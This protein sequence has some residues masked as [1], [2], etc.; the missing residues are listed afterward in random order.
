[1]RIDKIRIKNFRSFSDVEVKVAPYTSLVGP[2]GSGKSTILCA[3]NVF[4]RE[5]ENVATN[6]SDLDAEDFHNRNTEEPIEITVTFNELSDV[7]QKELKDYYRQDELVLGAE[8]QF[9]PVTQRAT[10]RQFGLRS[11]MAEFKEFF[12]LENDKKKVDELKAAYERIR[13]AF[14]ELPKPGSKDSMHDALRQYEEAHPELCVLIASPDQLYGIRGVGRL[15]PFIQWVY[16]PAV[17]DATKENVEAKNTALGKLLTRT[18]RAKVKFDDQIKKLKDETLAQYRSIVEAQQEALDELSVALTARLTQWAHPE[19]TARLTWNTEERK[20]QV[21]EPVARLLTGEGGFEGELA[22]FGHGLQRSYLLAL[23]QELASSNDTAA[24]RL[25]LGCEEPEIYQHPPQAR[26]LSAVLQSLGEGNA[27]VIVSTH[28]PHFVSGLGFESVRMV[29]R[30]AA[31]NASKVSQVTFEHISNRVAEVTGEKPKPIPALRARLQQALQPHL[32]EM[33]FTSKLILVEGPEDVAYIT[34][35]MIL[36]GRWNEFRKHGCHILPVTGKTNLRD[37]IVIAQALDIPV[38]VVFDSDGNIG[39]KDVPVQDRKTN[40]MLLNI[41]GEIH[42]NP[43][44][45]APVWG[46]AYAQWPTN[47]GDTLKSEVATTAW[48]E[49]RN[50]A[51][52]E[53]GNPEGISSKNAVFI[54]THLAALKEKGH[55]PASLERLCQ[56]IITFAAA[57]APVAAGAKG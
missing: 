44:P 39:G 28:S 52:K 3:L 32:N 13:S 6:L 47:L 51:T 53:L 20:V 29:R 35:W 43:F 4:F 25:I 1:M 16:V 26:H 33:F 49:T 56:E 37:P 30:D 11:V 21:E 41:L 46:A 40:E 9:D 36:S 54:G 55:V 45:N 38:Y 17:K 50:D 57:P 42:A 18:V 2:N 31:A 7:E 8:A 27:Q 22:R 24:P 23:L 12:A 19:V 14:P 48:E 10:V 15:S 5:T 34:S